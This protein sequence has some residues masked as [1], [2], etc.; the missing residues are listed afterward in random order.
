[1]LRRGSL[2][3]LWVDQLAPAM[4]RE[5]I[6]LTFELLG[7]RSGLPGP[8][9]VFSHIILQHLP[10]VFDQNGDPVIPLGSGDGL[11]YHGTTDSYIRIPRTTFICE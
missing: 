5:E 3:V 8:K 11:Y 6:L 7:H 4:D 2:A 9:I 1:M 10:F